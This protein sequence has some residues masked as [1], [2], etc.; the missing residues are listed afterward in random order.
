MK[1][2]YLIPLYL[3]LNLSVKALEI[4]VWYGDHQSFGHLGGHPQRWV[5]VLGHV[6]PAE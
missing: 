1:F 2:L 4:D 3:V 6:S 5:N